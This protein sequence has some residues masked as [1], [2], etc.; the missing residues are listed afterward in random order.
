MAKNEVFKIKMK[1]GEEVEVSGLIINKRWG[2]D[3]RT[4]ETEKVLKSGEKR[5]ALSSSF[6]M[7][8]I[9]EGYLVTSANTQKALKELANRPDMI[10]EDDPKKIMTAVCKFWNE[11]GWRG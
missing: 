7:T 5:T 6:Y 3:K 10:E 11:R 2:I 4:E 9:P 1:D 8:K